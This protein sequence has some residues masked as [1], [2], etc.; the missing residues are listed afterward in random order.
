MRHPLLL[1]PWPSLYADG[2]PGKG[3]AIAVTTIMVNETG[4]NASN[5]ALPAYEN[6]DEPGVEP[7]LISDVA[8]LNVDGTG[9]V[10]P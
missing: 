8:T 4:Q 5:Q 7:V 2:L 9:A 3:T 10:I 6:S 1:V